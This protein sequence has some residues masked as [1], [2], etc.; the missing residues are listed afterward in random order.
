MWVIDDDGGGVLGGRRIEDHGG[1][2]IAVDH[3]RIVVEQLLGHI[4]VLAKLAHEV[5]IALLDKRA[6]GD[7][8]FAQAPVVFDDNGRG[9][10]VIN[11][12]EK[13][14]R[15][16]SL[17]Q[18]RDDIIEDVEE[19]V[20]TLELVLWSV[21]KVAPRFYAVFVENVDDLGELF[22]A[23]LNNFVFDSVDA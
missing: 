13:S 15:F 2:F 17:A 7:S 23:W 5:G 18:R 21:L 6:H 1:D 16:A 22:G 11:A 8:G 10:F 14:L 19:G 9:N 3:R 4:A 20:V 12:G